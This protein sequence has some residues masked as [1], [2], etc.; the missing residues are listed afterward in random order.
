MTPAA[1]RC[2]EKSNVTLVNRAF[3]RAYLG[4]LPRCREEAEAWIESR[5]HLWVFSFSTV[6]ETL[7]LEPPAVRA[8]LRRM[9]TESPM[10]RG[11][12]IAK[13]YPNALHANLPI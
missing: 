12:A 11:F 8:A 5:H 13:S 7:G 10:L 4:A 1:S 2:R 6:C 9:R 3:V